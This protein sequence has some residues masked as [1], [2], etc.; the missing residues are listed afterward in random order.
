[1]SQNNRQGKENV[2]G[3]ENIQFHL[4]LFPVPNKNNIVSWF[5]NRAKQIKEDA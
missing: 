3:Y 2:Y 4:I 1:M 5:V